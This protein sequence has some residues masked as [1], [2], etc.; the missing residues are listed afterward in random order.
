MKAHSTRS[1]SLLEISA[2]NICILR[3]NLTF[4][5]LRSSMIQDKG[6]QK[7]VKYVLIVLLLWILAKPSQDWCCGVQESSKWNNNTGL[8]H[9]IS[10]FNVLSESVCLFFC[11]KQNSWL[12]LSSPQWSLTEVIKTATKTNSRALNDQINS[13]HSIPKLHPIRL[14]LPE[15][16]HLLLPRLRLSPAGLSMQNMKG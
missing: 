13:W 8:K 4:S 16:T 5:L 7:K 1:F 14:S 3:P 9:P 12:C 2:L 15:P 10:Y 11:Q 6:V